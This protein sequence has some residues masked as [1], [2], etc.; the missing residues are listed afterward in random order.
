M[1]QHLTEWQTCCSTLHSLSE[2]NFQPW[3]CPPTW[4]EPPWWLPGRPHL[5]WRPAPSASSWPRTTSEWAEWWAVQSSTSLWSVSSARPPDNGEDG[6]YL[7]AQ[8]G[9]TELS[10]ISFFFH[11]ASTRLCF[12]FNTKTRHRGRQIRLKRFS[13]QWDS[14][15]NLLHDWDWLTQC[16][17]TTLLQ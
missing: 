11:I 8:T 9:L 2:M 4:Q 1:I 16:C 17:S 3:A 15:L 14:F 7:W 12:L 10:K 6:P 5:S 13:K